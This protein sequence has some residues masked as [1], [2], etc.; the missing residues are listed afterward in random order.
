[1]NTSMTT[2]PTL[3]VRVRDARDGEAWG[4]FVDAYAPLVYG[5]CARRGL[6]PADAADVAQDVMR[7]VAA[8]IPQ[9]EY[10]PAKG[11]FRDWLFAVTRSKL[12]THLSRRGR[13]PRGS[14]ETAVQE[15]LEAQ[16]GPA[17]SAEWD[18]SWQQ[19]A[20]DWA[21][22]QVKGEFQ[23]ATWR[24]FWATAVEGRPAA[25]VAAELKLTPGAVYI[26]RS[27]VLKRIRAAVEEIDDRPDR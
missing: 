25:V 26:A 3:L 24:A 10:D 8:A 22:A 23:P 9:F 4:R 7:A 17:E 11:S 2:Q 19:Q 15:L 21:A 20:F 16:P 12:N 6:Q 13:H 14:G 5:Y 27:R 18:R 1:M